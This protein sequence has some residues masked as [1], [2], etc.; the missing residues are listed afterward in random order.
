VQH[1]LARGACGDASCTQRAEGIGEHG[2]KF[3]PANMSWRIDGYVDVRAVIAVEHHAGDQA[4]KIVSEA[5]AAIR[6][7]GRRLQLAHHPFDYGV[8]CGRVVRKDDP[9]IK[10]PGM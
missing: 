6:L 9:H 5:N 10:P 4:P 3:T 1:V 2:A 7:H 8:I